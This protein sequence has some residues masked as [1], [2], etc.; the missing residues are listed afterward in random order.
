MLALIK[1]AGDLAS[2]V[3]ARLYR[4]GIKVV[5]TDLPKPTAIRRTVS[6]CRAITEGSAEVEGIE[7][8]YARNADEARSIISGVKIAVL[9]DALAL[10][11]EAL[12]PDALIDAILA[13]RNTGTSI[14]DAR[15]VIA[16]GPGFT[17]GIDCHAVVETMRGHNLGRVLWN[18]SA[19]PN[20]GVPGMIGGY[21]SE[22]LLRAPCE[23][24]WT[25]VTDIGSMVAAGETI[26]YV[27]GTPVYAEISG[28]V[29]GML[30][31]GTAVT[32]GFK[33]GDID[34]RGVMDNCYSISDKARAI[35]GGVLEALLAITGV[36][37][38]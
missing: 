12:Q 16:L 7:A 34:P 1:G 8:L 38:E 36:I 31:S 5:M 19:A 9:A 29:R 35:G 4:V 23:G 37:K 3:A 10:C 25:A 21:A 13:K 2:G 14:T 22:R 11:R 20:T 18:G 30:P 17:A 15:A 26:A 6:F 33:C 28:V 27:D 24:T 32:D